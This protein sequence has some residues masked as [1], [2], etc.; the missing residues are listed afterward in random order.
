MSG[1]DV[2]ERPRPEPSDLTRPFWDAAREHRLVRQVCDD[3]GRSF[4]TPQIACPS[5]LSTAW[6]WTPSTGRGTVYSATVV[7]RAPYPGFTSPYHVVMVDLEEDWTMLS[8]LVGTGDHP[9]ALG[10]AVEVDWL[11]L[12]DEITLPVFRPADEGSGR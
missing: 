11:A 3:C 10:S 4:F 1:V 12:D 7:H 8:N 2:A 5:C 6:T 9:V